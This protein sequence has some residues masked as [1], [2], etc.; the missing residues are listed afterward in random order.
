MFDTIVHRSTCSTLDVVPFG[1]DESIR[2][3]YPE[4]AEGV[5]NLILAATYDAEYR[6]IVT[7]VLITRIFVPAQQRGRGAGRHLLRLCTERADECGAVL[8]VH[9]QAYG[10]AEDMRSADLVEWY[11]RA[12]FTSL[13]GDGGEFLARLPRRRPAPTGELGNPALGGVAP[14]QGATS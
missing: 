7:T 4:I 3:L 9:A 2:T 1:A 10:R 14:A 8:L 13:G 6:D 12:G 5:A 11:R